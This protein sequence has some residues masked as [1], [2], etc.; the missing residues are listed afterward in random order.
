[1]Q[2]TVRKENVTLAVKTTYIDIYYRCYY[3]IVSSVVGT[4]YVEK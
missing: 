2:I 4:Y 1:M 3:D